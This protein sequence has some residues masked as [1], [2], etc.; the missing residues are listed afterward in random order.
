[1]K[2][3]KVSVPLR[4]Y[5]FEMVVFFK[6]GGLSNEVSVPLRGYGFEITLFT[7]LMAFGA[8]AFP[9]PYGDMVLKYTQ[10]GCIKYNSM[11]PSPYG[12]MVLKYGRSWLS[13]T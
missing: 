7:F 12:D 1:M 2:I 6:K 8:L 4:G 13:C 11:F 3:I 9:S 5:G 10:Y